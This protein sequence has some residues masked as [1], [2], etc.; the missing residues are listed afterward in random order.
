V[1]KFDERKV[2]RQGWSYIVSLPMPWA[3]IMSSSLK[4]VNVEMD[5]ESTLR[6]VAGDVRQDYPGYNCNSTPSKEGDEQ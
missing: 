2:S 5:D 1:I 6:I 4:T 3:Q